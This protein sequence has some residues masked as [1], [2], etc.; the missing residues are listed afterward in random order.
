V[1]DTHD[2]EAN[3]LRLAVLDATDEVAQALE[4]G[5]DQRQLAAGRTVEDLVRRYNELL[6]R[7]DEADRPRVESGLGR[8]VT[9]LRRAA[10][11]LTRRSSGSAAEK[12]RDAGFVPFLEQR[13]PGRSMEGGRAFKTRHSPTYSVGGEVEA[14]CGKCKE[15]REHHIVAIVGG[16]PKQ[17]ICQTCRSKHGYRTTPGPRDQPKAAPSAATPRR[18]PSAEERE[19]QRRAAE[20]RALVDELDAAVSPRPFDPRARYKVGEIIVHP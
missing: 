5:E 19:A 8:R 15:L 3:A 18:A 9:D 7:L 12:S 10:A 2:E 20:R 4:S 11:Q 14:W 17:V 1:N 16:E 13:A 6:A